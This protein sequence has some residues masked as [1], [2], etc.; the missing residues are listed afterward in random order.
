MLRKI[1][2]ASIQSLIVTLVCVAYVMSFYQ[3][4]LGP[5]V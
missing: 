3:A 4:A 1:Y 5:M 2:Q